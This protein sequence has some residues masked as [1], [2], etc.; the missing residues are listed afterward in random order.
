MERRKRFHLSKEN[1]IGYEIY[2]LTLCCAHRASAFSKATLAA[3]IVSILK[4]EAARAGFLLHAWCLMPD[5]LHVLVDGTRDDADL[6]RF[7]TRF[8]RRSTGLRYYGGNELWQRN[9]YDHIVRNREVLAKVAG[10]I[11][12]NPVRK[13]M[14]EFVNEYP[15]SGSLTMPWKSASDDPWIP[16]W[17]DKAERADEK[18]RPLRPPSCKHRL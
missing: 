5:H 8:K 1:Y 6:F 17:K 14:C 15:Y 12:M 4:D 13:G 2:F 7:V 18:N 9:F 11:W 3:E 16:P 10:Y